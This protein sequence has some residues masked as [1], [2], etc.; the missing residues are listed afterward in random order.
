MVVTAVNS[1]A[2]SFFKHGTSHQTAEY[3]ASN[4]NTLRAD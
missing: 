3:L 1:D 2:N 4:P